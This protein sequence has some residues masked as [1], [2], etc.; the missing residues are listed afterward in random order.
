[1]ECRGLVLTAALPGDTRGPEN[2]K[3]NTGEES[4]PKGNSNSLNMTLCNTCLMVE[5]LRMKIFS[6]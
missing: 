1:M 4:G 2:A 6:S 3:T 5:A